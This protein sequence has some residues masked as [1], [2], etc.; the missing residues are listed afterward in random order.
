M[1]LDIVLLDHQPL[2]NRRH[3]VVLGDHLSVRG[4]EHAEN[5]EGA[6]SQFDRHAIT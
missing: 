3:E 1:D 5:I 2:P 6:A 4:S